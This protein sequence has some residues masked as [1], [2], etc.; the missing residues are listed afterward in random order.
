MGLEVNRQATDYYFDY[1]NAVATL[2]SPVI[3]YKRAAELAME[4]L[5][6]GVKIRDL[7]VEK[8]LLSGEQI[9][10]L[11]EHSYQPNLHIV[12][13]IIGKKEEER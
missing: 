9:N 7:V 2:L 5:G 12:R 1:S 3:G 4:A 8:G 6:R 11:I 10:E 13:K